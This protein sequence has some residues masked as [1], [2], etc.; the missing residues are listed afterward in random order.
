MAT[1]PDLLAGDPDSAEAGVEQLQPD[2]STDFRITARPDEDPQSS[3]FAAEDLPKAPA[4]KYGELFVPEGG[5]KQYKKGIAALHSMPVS[6]SHSLNTR[7][8]MDAIV[9]LVQIH[10]RKMPKA[11]REM[12]RE[13]EASPMFRVTKGELRKTAGIMSKKFSRVED[14]LDMLHEQRIHWNILGEDNEVQWNMRSRFL[15]SWGEG[16]GQYAGQVCFSIDPRVQE[17]ILEPRLWVALNLDVQKQLGTET[18]YALYQNAWRYIGTDNKVTAD[19]TVATWIELLMGQC[20]YVRT[21]E[22]GG[23]HVVDYSEWK[24]RYLKPAIEK[25][26]SISALGHT[27]KLIEKRSGLKVKRL[28]FQFI[29]KRQ[30]KLETPITWPDPVLESLKSL[31][32]EEEELAEMAQGFSLDEVVESLSRFRQAEERKKKSQE[33]IAAPKAF[34]HGILANVNTQATLDDEAMAA[35]EKKAR[36]EEVER[37]AKEQSERATYD[38]NQHQTRR[39]IDNIASWPPERKAQLL[40]RFDQSPAG[41]KVRVLVA[42]GWEKAGHGAWSILKTWLAQ[43]HQEDFFE[44]LPNPEDRTLEAWLLWRL[45]SPPAE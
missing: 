16:L 3:L 7:R 9:A 38:F 42:K 11:Q 14:I 19:F 43:E 28:Q 41:A 13:L 30:E 35:I 5:I 4:P 17:L 45:H 12:L 22:N 18:S 36:T 25:V 37:R 23:K 39:L 24:A 27:L 1:D 32:F 26:N 33:R 40:Q 34:F 2:E 6:G 31:G 10:Y 15:A 29:P 21:L 44:L 20:R 8:V